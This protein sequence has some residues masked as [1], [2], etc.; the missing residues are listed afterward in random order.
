[1]KTIVTLLILFSTISLFGQAD[2]SKNKEQY[3]EFMITGRPLRFDKKISIVFGQKYLSEDSMQCTELVEKIQSFFK[4]EDVLEFMNNMG[5]TLT[6][7]YATS[8]DHFF[9]YYYIM[10]KEVKTQ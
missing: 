10:K 9:T 2:S 7:G 4:V 1:M 5:W 8:H 3:F 6:T